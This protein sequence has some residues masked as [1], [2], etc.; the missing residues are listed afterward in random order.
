MFEGARCL[1]GKIHFF[2]FLN[3]W[4]VIGSRDATLCR[5]NILKHGESQMCVIQRKKEP[6]DHLWMKA[7]FNLLFTF[8]DI[9]LGIVK[10]SALSCFYGS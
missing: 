10:N 7:L 3:C 2:T 9:V 5:F 8:L 4:F 1:K 6:N